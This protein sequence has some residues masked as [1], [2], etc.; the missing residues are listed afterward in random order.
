VAH[1]LALLLPEKLLQEVVA[2]TVVAA[3]VVYTADQVEDLAAAGRFLAHHSQNC[4]R[5]VA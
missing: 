1:Y 3:S 5:S 4:F 2:G